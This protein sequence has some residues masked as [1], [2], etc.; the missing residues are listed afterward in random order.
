VSE[1]EKGMTEE[2]R[3]I[4]RILNTDLIGSNVVSQELMKIKGIGPILARA[5]LVKAGIPINK[6]VGLLTDEELSK[7]EEMVRNIHD[8]FPEYM[9]NR[10]FD[11]F[12][13]ESKHLIGSDLTFAI[14]RDIEFEK[15]IGS[16]RGIR[17]RLG[18]KVRGQRTKTTGRK[19]KRPVGVKRKKK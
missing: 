13:G 19:T 10:R 8:Y 2:F 5:I 17:H 6:R 7:I 14:E 4:V 11:R 1:V 18:L 3:E 15:S 12:T 9:L 16:W